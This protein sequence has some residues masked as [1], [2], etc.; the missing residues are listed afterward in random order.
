MKEAVPLSDVGNEISRSNQKCLPSF[1]SRTGFL[2]TAVA[3]VLFGSLIL[4][5]GLLRAGPGD[6]D[7]TFGSG[8]KVAFGITGSSSNDYGQGLAIQDD[9]KIVSIGYS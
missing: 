5:P 9:G 8:G 3:C 6:L 7:P 2:G 4:P 1:T